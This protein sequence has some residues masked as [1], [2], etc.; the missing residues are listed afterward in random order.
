MTEMG[1]M[2]LSALGGWTERHRAVYKVSRTSK[3]RAA[4]EDGHL[5]NDHL[6]NGHLEKGPKSESGGVMDWMHSEAD[7]TWEMVPL[8]KQ[9]F[10]A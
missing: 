9:R 1:S 6:W 5:W 7:R 3:V 4:L 2:T 10:Q 8:Q